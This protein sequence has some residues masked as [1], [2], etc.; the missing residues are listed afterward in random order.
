MKTATLVIMVEEAKTAQARVE[1]VAEAATSCVT[2][3]AAEEAMV[4]ITRVE[5][6]ATRLM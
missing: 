4:A 6:M 2:L 3:A 5:V 1:E